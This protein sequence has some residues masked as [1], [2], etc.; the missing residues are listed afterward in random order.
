MRLSEIASNLSNT[1]LTLQ[2]IGKNPTINN[3][4]AVENCQQGDLTF[5]T[6]QN[7]LDAVLIKNPAAIVVS[8]QLAEVAKTINNV[9]FLVTNN[10]KLAHALIKQSYTDRDF[11]D[12]QW[13]KIHPSAVIHN[14]AKIPKS[15]FVAPNVTIGQNTVLGERCKILAGVVI[16]NDV[17]IGDDCILHPNCVIGYKSQIGNKVEIG[18]CTVLGAEGFGF[19]QDSNGKS[20]KIPQTGHVVIEDNVLLGAFNTIDRATYGVTTIGAGTKTD[21]IIHIAHNVTVGKN[22]LFTPMLAVAGSVTIGD[23]CIT[24]GQ[25]QIA[26]HINIGDDVVLVHRAG[27]YKD[28]SK[29]GMYSG[30]PLK[31]FKQYMKDEAQISKLSQLNKKIKEMERAITALQQIK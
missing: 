4:A 14:T 2:H 9:G 25:S 13:Q 7:Y 21:N 10:V 18:A 23:R 11:I 15:C 17:T 20:Y 16:E 27:V 6:T 29:P 12:E 19:A 24:S 30:L 31:P 1:Q 8:K 26:D 28:I 3:I 5:A 22:C